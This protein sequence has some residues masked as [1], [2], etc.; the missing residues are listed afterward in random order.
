MASR[1]KR[2]R[3]L[4]EIY[5]QAPSLACKG[6]CWTACAAIPVFQLE[7]DL[8]EQ[9]AGRPL[10]RLDVDP[11][12]AHAVLGEPDLRCPS[13]LMGRCSIYEARPLICRL[14][15]A[16][17]GLECP[18]GCAPERVLTRDEVQAMMTWMAKLT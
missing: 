1:G 17:A 5:D 4:R 2:L 6:L 12:G 7:A 10:A 14:Y 13:L 18:H 9:A 11:G 3:I 16:A 8:M 15:G